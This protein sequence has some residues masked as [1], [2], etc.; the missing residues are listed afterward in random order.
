MLCSGPRCDA[1]RFVV[2]LAAG[3]SHGSEGATGLV[4]AGMAGALAEGAHAFALNCLRDGLYLPS[5]VWGA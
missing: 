4:G 2:R 3:T 1:D 5:P